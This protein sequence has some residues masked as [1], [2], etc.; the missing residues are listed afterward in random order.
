M[1]S[2]AM[3]MVSTEYIQMK[4]PDEAIIGLGWKNDLFMDNIISID[5]INYG[6]KKYE[7][8]LERYPSSIAGIMFPKQ[9]AFY[10]TMD[11]IPEELLK[12]AINF[13]LVIVR[14]SEE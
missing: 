7:E 12:Q 1:I 6:T 2:E 10:E 13:D 11:Q 3:L 8:L 4:D 14:H 9:S 5:Y